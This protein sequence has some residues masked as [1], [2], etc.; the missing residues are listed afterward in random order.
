MFHFRH[1][2]IGQQGRPAEVSTREFHNRADFAFRQFL[3][4]VEGF[5]AFQAIH[6]A[7]R[8]DQPAKWANPMW[9]ELAL[10]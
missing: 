3:G 10:W 8:R 4:W 2:P 1:H 7:A 9:R 5:A 6:F